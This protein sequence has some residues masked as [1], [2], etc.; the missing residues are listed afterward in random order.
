[1]PV[2]DRWHAACW[3]GEADLLTALGRCY[4]NLSEARTAWRTL[5]RAI[6][7]YQ[8]QGDG[9]GMARA[10]VELL[11]IW[12]P[13][14]RQRAMADE[15]LTLLR[16]GDPHLRAL[17]LLRSWRQD[18]AIELA[19]RHGLEDVLAMVAADR[20]TWMPFVRGRVDEGIAAARGG[21]EL[22][23]RMGNYHPAAGF[24]RGAAFRTLEA[25]LLDLGDGVAA[26]AVAYAR[27]VHLR[28][29]EQLA[30]LD[31][32]GVAFARAD[33]ARCESLITETPTHTDFRADLYR[34]WI[35]ELRGDIPAA[36]AL[37]VDP[38]RG[39]GA[40]TALSQ[41]NA[42]AAGLLF[43]AGRGDAARDA[44][45]AWARIARE[46]Q[47]LC[48]EAPALVD[49][50]VALGADDL[51]REIHDAYEKRVG[52][53]VYST[54]Q[55]RGDAAARAAIALRLGLVQLAR[56]QYE[57][58]LAWAERERCPIDAGCCLLGLARVDLAEDDRAAAEVHFDRAGA[59]F[60]RMG[61]RFYLDQAAEARGR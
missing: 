48:D 51:L 13:P 58:G 32:V 36:L 15:A 35:A 18:E 39:G 16:G 11:R 4:W 60:E 29:P 61:A 19:A 1:V 14:E 22:Y 21:H 12:G 40:T 28:F 26:E 34:M 44:L 25:G 52:G 27:A 9:V 49:C 30:L 53:I 38:E 10:T 59:I 47:S 6:A 41:I 43:H 54:L 46:G 20:D 55:G 37:M 42:A 23:A 7:L 3:R 33:F 8:G 24:L 2:S 45:D 5:R 56:A 17:L 31:R 57:H 50:L